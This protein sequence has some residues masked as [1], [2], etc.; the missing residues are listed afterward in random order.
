MLPMIM[1]RSYFPE[2]MEDFFSDDFL[3]G[4]FNRQTGE[5]LPAVN[6]SETENEY[7][8]DVA[9]PGLEK[10]DFQIEI[11]DNLITISS[12]K[13]EKNEDRKENYTRREFSYT[14][15]RRSFTLPEKVDREKIRAAHKDGI[16]RVNIPKVAEE[17]SKL[18][19]LIKIS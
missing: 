12:A 13:E 5:N 17:K 19:K 3:P 10:K 6:V 2:L 1:R 14:S 8:I 11:E 16:L 7:R 18:K 15:F 9:A 4:L